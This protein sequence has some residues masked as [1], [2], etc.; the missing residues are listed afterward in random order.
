MIY[1]YPLPYLVGKTLEVRHCNCWGCAGE[2]LLDFA[3]GFEKE[4]ITMIVD[5]YNQY[6]ERR[7]AK[8]EGKV[9]QE[10]GYLYYFSLES[11]IKC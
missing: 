8:L 1:T 4:E 5:E 2:T 3:S 10:G 6:H 7:Q 9:V 11:P